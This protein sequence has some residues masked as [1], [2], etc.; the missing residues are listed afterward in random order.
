MLT[1]LLCCIY[2]GWV[3][4]KDAIY[5]LTNEGDLGARLA[6]VWFLYVKFILPLIIAVIFGYGIFG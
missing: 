2:V 1:A 5:E 3:L 4:K 6:G